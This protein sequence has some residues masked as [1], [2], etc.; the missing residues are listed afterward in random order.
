MHS[1]AIERGRRARAIDARDREN[2]R[3][4]GRTKRENVDNEKSDIH[5]SKRPAGTSAAASIRRLRKDRPDI[6]A[7]VLAGELSPHAG[8]IEAGFRKVKVDPR[9]IEKLESALALI[10]EVKQHCQSETGALFERL[11]KLRNRED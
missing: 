7:R 3:G 9:A 5:I 2:L 11:D 1:E 4:R 8:M 6:H 10:R